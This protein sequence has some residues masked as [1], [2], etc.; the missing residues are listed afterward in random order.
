MNRLA[1]PSLFLLLGACGGEREASSEVESAE[2]PEE[3]AALGEAP[4]EIGE[5]SGSEPEI[6]IDP[7][8]TAAQSV[9]EIHGLQLTLNPNG[10][11]QLS[12]LDRWGTRLD[13]N[14]ASMEYF[15]NAL[16]VLERSVTDEQFAGLEAWA[17]AH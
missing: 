2:A 5:A 6:V 11:I 4:G 9:D 12:G 10:T 1:F 17:A 16:E 3:S 15:E 13:A 8:P 14:Y 7:V